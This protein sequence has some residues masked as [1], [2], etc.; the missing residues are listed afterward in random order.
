MVPELIHSAIVDP[1]TIIRTCLIDK[2]ASPN[3]H[4]ALALLIATPNAMIRAFAFSRWPDLRKT[5]EQ[6]L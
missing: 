6:D 4:N 3:D 1:M 2:N 5:A